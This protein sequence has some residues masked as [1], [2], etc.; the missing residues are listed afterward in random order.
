MEMFIGL[1]FTSK[2]KVASRILQVNKPITSKSIL[3]MPLEIWLI[4]LIQAKLLNGICL[5]KSSLKSK[6]TVINGTFSM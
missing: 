6:V 3:N 5:S 4:I 1:N 2:L